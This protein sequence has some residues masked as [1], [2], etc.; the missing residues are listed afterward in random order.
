[1]TKIVAFILFIVGFGLALNSY[2]Q[3]NE[4]TLALHIELKSTSLNGFQMLIPQ[5]I[6]EK[7]THQLNKELI[8]PNACTIGE[9]GSAKK[10]FQTTVYPSISASVTRTSSDAIQLQ[11]KTR[12]LKKMNTY[13][14]D[15]CSV[16]SPS[17]AIEK[18][19][20]MV[21]LSEHA[22]KIGDLTIQISTQVIGRTPP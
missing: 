4:P 14:V 8:Y 17:W 18:H 11:W 9:D 20:E 13:T 19:D 10:S 6:G 5:T 21:S 16:E 15:A 2:S 3:K 1:M 22:T 7:T 12:Q